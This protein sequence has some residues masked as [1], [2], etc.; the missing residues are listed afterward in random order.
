MAATGIMARCESIHT[1]SSN[2]P[3]LPDQGEYRLNLYPKS[4]FRSHLFW[5][6]LVGL[7]LTGLDQ[8]SRDDSREV[9]IDAAAIN[10][11]SQLWE[12]QMGQPPTAAELSSITESWI[13]EELY[14]REA[15]RLGLDQNDTIV[16]RR[17]VQKLR[18]L[19]IESS[20]LEPGEAEV[21][22][23]FEANRDR[24]RLAASTTFSQVLIR[25]PEPQRLAR[26]KADLTAGADYR[27][28][29]DASS[30]LADYVD[31]TPDEIATEFGINFVS[32]LLEVLESDHRANWAGPI[33]SI[34]GVHYIRV[35]EFHPPRIPALNEVYADVVIDLIDEHQQQQATQYL[36]SL[37]Q[38]YHII[39]K[40]LADDP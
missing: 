5:F 16:R 27:S 34:H 28:I 13:D 9:I 37:R 36:D 29:G 18:F 30:L 39:R 1:N 32:A 15:L 7:A 20:A 11:L 23:F 6:V 25:H 22:T 21:A 3:G 12:A 24:Y 35:N 10:R 19:E 17:L 4:V 38:R 14:Y 33:E 8:L 26:I 31:L 2:R 40:D